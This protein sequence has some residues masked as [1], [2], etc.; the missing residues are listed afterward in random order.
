MSSIIYLAALVAECC[1]AT[2]LVHLE[3]AVAIN[4]DQGAGTSGSLP[5]AVTRAAVPGPVGRLMVIAA[6]EME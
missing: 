4:F 3:L 1:A 2:Q 6:C 5:N